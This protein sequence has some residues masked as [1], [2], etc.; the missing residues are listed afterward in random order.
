[1]NGK[2]KP[3]ESCPAPASAPS[4]ILMGHGGG[5]L[6]TRR[7]LES[8]FLPAFD[9]PFL[10]QD[11]D[12]AV[13]PPCEGNLV[14]TA[15]SYVVQPLFFPGGDIGTLAVY[16]TV[17]DL[18]MCGAVPR[19]LTAAFILE[20]GLEIE[21]L[22]RVAESMQRAARSAQVQI[23][24]GDTKVV[25]RRG[26]NSGMFISTSGA[27]LARPGVSLPPASVREGDAILLSGDIGRHGIAVMACREGLRFEKTI[28]SDCA[29]LAPLVDSLLASGAAVRCLRDLTR[30]G[31]GMALNEIARAAGLNLL[32]Q[33]AAIP[34]AEE[35]RGACEILGLDPVYVA[36]EGRFIAFVAAESAQRALAALR[37]RPDGA[38]AQLIGHVG[39]SGKGRVEILSTMGVLRP[40]D[41][42]SGEQLPR[43]C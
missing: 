4:R 21:T 26:E 15:D 3:G 11:A 17:N 14:L 13:L 38:T 37:A 8:I 10:R 22:R 42:P 39:K 34:V 5:G 28:E 18:A 2:I 30:G 1:M 29:N 24:A 33:E 23:V 41:M 25:E 27:G 31:L 19:Y 40:L 35:V 16:G 36:N 43:I 9:N 12:G 32:V 6:L 7:L 20:E